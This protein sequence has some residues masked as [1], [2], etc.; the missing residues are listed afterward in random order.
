MVVL[1]KNKKFNSAELY[2]VFFAIIQQLNESGNR[3]IR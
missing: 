2:T 3:L 1:L